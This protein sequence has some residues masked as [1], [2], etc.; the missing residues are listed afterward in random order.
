MNGEKGEQPVPGDELA[1]IRQRPMA[2]DMR[3]EAGS[4]VIPQETVDTKCYQHHRD[5]R[6]ELGGPLRSLTGF[7]CSNQYCFADQAR[8]S[9]D[10]GKPDDEPGVTKTAT[11]KLDY[12]F[13]QQRD[14]P[15]G[16]V[17]ILKTES[18]RLAQG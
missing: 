7:D 2:A 15:S 5:C 6:C 17:L 11:P 18:E 14:H 9:S 16:A 8:Q 13:L 3:Q 10:Y 4:F 1:P 12:D